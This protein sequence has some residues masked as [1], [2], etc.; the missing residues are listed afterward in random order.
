MGPW[1]LKH[2]HMEAQRWSGASPGHTARKLEPGGNTWLL[3]PLSAGW[4]WVGKAEA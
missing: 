3:H 4:A 2:R 1:G